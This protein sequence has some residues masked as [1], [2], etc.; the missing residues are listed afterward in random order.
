MFSKHMRYRDR[1]NWFSQN[2]CFYF[3]NAFSQTTTRSYYKHFKKIENERFMDFL[4][5]ALVKIFITL[6][7]QTYFLTYARMHLIIMLHEKKYIHGNNKPFMTK[8]LSKSIMS[9]TRFRDKFLENPTNKNKLAYTSQKN[10]RVS[11]PRK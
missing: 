7:I 9:R 11:F 8:A 6:K 1:I 4:C 2:G 10:F 5:L 3:K